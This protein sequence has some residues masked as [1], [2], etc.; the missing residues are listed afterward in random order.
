MSLLKQFI[1]EEDGAGM[2]EY[3]LLVALIAVAL[4]GVVAY[5]G[6]NIFGVFQTAGETLEGGVAPA[7]GTTEYDGSLSD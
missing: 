2:V 6:S 5:L 7:D 3:G 4:I 1:Y